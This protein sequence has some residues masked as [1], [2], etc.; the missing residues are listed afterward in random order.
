MPIYE[1]ICSACG[2]GFEELVRS[3]S[4]A[5]R[6]TCPSCG[7]RQV[8]RKLSVFAAR[9]GSGSPP[10]CGPAGGA[11]GSCCAQDGACPMLD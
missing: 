9:E 3:M 1:Y 2:H 11:C 5:A 4:A 6:Q 8:E 7:G 10:P